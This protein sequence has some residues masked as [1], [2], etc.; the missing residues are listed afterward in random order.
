V[1]AFYDSRRRVLINANPTPH[2]RRAARLESALG[3]RGAHLAR[4]TQ[5][6]D[7]LHEP[8]GPGRCRAAGLVSGAGAYGLHTYEI[9]LEAAER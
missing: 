6:I 8:S 7:D 4:V 3:E 2:I 9:N 1:L 5:S